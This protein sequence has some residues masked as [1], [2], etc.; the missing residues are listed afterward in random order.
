M[1]HGSSLLLPLAY[2]R[3]AVY[4]V[5]L[6]LFVEAHFYVLPELST[7]IDRGAFLRPDDGL[8]VPDRSPP[9]PGDGPAELNLYLHVGPGKCGKGAR[10]ASTTV[11]DIIFVERSHVRSYVC[12][13][14]YPSHR[15]DGDNDDTSCHEGG[16]DPSQ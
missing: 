7:C 6:Y 8:V 9:T 11:R 3:F 2:L 1:G 4:A 10:F 16:Q 15:Q 5:V 13:L 14:S 12:S